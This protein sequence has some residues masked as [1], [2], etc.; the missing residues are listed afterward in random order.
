MFNGN[1]NFRVKNKSPWFSN[2]WNPWPST[3]SFCSGKL[4]EVINKYVYP[5]GDWTE[6]FDSKENASKGIG[7]SA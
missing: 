3:F 1:F 7:K 2:T 6:I 4:P 5:W